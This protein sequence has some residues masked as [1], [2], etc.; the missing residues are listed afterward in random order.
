MSGPFNQA[1]VLVSFYSHFREE[2]NIL[3]LIFEKKMWLN[4]YTEHSFK[5]G[6]PQK[7]H[8]SSGQS[9]KRGGGIR[10]C[11]LGKKKIY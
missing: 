9:N 10:G 11:P 3:H 4:H 8:L 2:N 5:L 7:K 6:K 1:D